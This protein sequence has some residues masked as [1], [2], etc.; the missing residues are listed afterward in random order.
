MLSDVT[1]RDT[2]VYTCRAMNDDA[3][4]DAVAYVRVVGTYAVISGV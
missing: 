3:A 4:A 1:S 2:G